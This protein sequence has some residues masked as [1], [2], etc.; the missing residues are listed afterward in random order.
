[1]KTALWV[2]AFA[3]MYGIVENWF[4]SIHWQVKG[5]RDF[6]KR[7]DDRSIKIDSLLSI[8]DTFTRDSIERDKNG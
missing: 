1:M 5:K 4:W 3:Q 8:Y 2:I 6:N 7:A